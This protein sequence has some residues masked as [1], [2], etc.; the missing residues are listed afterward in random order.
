MLFIPLSNHG[1][2]LSIQP[3]MFNILR[4]SVL[5]REM[6]LLQ[7]IL[8]NSCVEVSWR[9][10]NPSA[11]ADRLRIH[12]SLAKKKKSIL[13]AS[14]FHLISGCRAAWGEFEL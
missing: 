2:Q 11:I 14:V 5:P 6:R 13:I 8:S 9:L 1:Y 12:G 4:S 3:E 7:I 10:R